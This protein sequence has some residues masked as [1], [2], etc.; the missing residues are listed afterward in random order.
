MTGNIF[1]FSRVWFLGE[2]NLKMI[3][4]KDNSDVFLKKKYLKIVRK[5]IQS[6]N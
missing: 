6:A 4:Q 5:T 2:V 3:K 1:L